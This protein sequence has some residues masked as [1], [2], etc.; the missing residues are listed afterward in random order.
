MA[1]H[2]GQF[3]DVLK[4][5]HWDVLRTSCFNV[6]RTSVE[7]ILRTSVG[8]VTSRYTED[9]MGT[10]IGRFLETSS[11]SPPD[12]IFPSGYVVAL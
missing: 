12:V 1:L 10:S 6:L 8:N 5:L 9:H 2:I 3:G 4:T 11:G 7:D